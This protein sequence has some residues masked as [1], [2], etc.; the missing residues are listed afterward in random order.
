MRTLKLG[1]VSLGVFTLAMNLACAG[2]VSSEKEGDIRIETFTEAVEEAA[3]DAAE[4]AEGVKGDG[5]NSAACRAYI[6]AYNSASCIPLDLDAE[7][8]CGS[9]D[10]AGAPDMTA[11]YDCMAGISCD[12]PIPKIP[13]CT[14]FTP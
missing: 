2:L 10:I 13:D 11:F 6:E 8:T 7:T 3:A 1:T 12:G 4:A 14:A 5:S 9:L